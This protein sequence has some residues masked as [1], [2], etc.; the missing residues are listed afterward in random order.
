MSDSEV[1]NLADRVA[2]LDFGNAG[3]FHGA[4]APDVDIAAL[5]EMLTRQQRRQFISCY[6]RAMRRK[7]EFH[8]ELTDKE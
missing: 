2:G 7:L 3:V 6:L 8:L 1:V 4:V 5:R